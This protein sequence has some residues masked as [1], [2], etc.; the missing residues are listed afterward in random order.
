MQIVLKSQGG[1]SAPPCTLLPVP[2]VSKESGDIGVPA[3][4]SQS[5]P[6]ELQI[7]FTIL[8][9]LYIKKKIMKVIYGNAISCLI[10]YIKNILNMKFSQL[11]A[12]SVV[13]M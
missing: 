12:R 4:S 3:L 1:A 9:K 8:V 2:L 13:N 7:S 11:S 6:W 10:I 5:P